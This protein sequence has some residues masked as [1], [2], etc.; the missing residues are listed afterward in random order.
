MP[1]TTD[2]QAVAKATFNDNASPASNSRS[3]VSATYQ[4]SVK[5]RQTLAIA[6]SLNE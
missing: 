6:E 2:A 3:D 5:P 4:R 1:S